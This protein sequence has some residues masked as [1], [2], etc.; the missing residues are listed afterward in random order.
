MI[1]PPFTLKNKTV[2]SVDTSTFE[3]QTIIIRF[4]LLFLPFYWLCF[5]PD[6]LKAFSE[7]KMFKIYKMLIVWQRGIYLLLP[8]GSR[9]L[10]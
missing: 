7:S 8:L 1:F 4:L 6:Y 2:N 9:I 5:G 3:S 10:M